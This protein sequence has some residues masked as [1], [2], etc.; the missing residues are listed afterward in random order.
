M[1]H[2]NRVAVKCFIHVNIN[3][4]LKNKRKVRAFLVVIFLFNFFRSL[5][6]SRPIFEY[7]TIAVFCD[8]K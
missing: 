1:A 3:K 7:I 4:S 2:R 6:L 8:N 5:T